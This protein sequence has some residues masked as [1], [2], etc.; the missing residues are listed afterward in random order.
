MSSPIDKLSFEL[1]AE[2]KRR[3]RLFV[4][5]NYTEPSLSDFLVTENA[6]LIGASIALE[7][8]TGE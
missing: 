1:I 8:H 5:D 4:A 2:I 3:T 6:M 7:L